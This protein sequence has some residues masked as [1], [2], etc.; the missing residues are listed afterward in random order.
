MIF[1]IVFFFK[2]FVLKETLKTESRVNKNR[3]NVHKSF[4]KKCYSFSFE[5]SLFLEFFTAF[6]CVFELETYNRFVLFY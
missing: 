6:F 3:E 1:S 4:D 5:F 2:F